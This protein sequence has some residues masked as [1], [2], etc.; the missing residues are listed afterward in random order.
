MGRDATS[1]RR[2]SSVAHA[3]EVAIDTYTGGH[4][5]PPIEPHRA[6]HDSRGAAAPRQPVLKVRLMIEHGV[7]CFLLLSLS[8][9]CTQ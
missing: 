6:T 9:K 4:F 8:F 1:P 7:L 2:M 5:V 3:S